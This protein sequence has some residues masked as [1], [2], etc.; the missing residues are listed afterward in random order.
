MKE[1]NCSCVSIRIPKHE[2]DSQAFGNSSENELNL[3]SSET[4][5]LCSTTSPQDV[6]SDIRSQ[7][8]GNDA[9][10]E[11]ALR[12]QGR[13]CLPQRFFFPFYFSL[14]PPDS[15]SEIQGHS[16]IR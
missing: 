10:S 8:N 5:F 12:I 13:I 15:N 3:V 14:S 1:W 4:A 6:V 16:P 7:R 11:K 9:E 2:L